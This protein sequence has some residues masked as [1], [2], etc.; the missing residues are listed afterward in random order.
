MEAEIR[1]R[2]DA[3]IHARHH[4]PAWQ[5]LAARRAPL[6]LSCLQTLFEQSQDGVGLDDALR[7]LA[8]MLADHANAGEFEIG[9]E[10]F[11]AQARK[12]LRSWIRLSLVV[13]REGR[14]YATDAFEEALRFVTALGG[15]IM[16]STA[17]R[18]SVVQREIEGLESSLNPDPQSRTVHL[19]H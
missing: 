18:L 5:L 2:T 14:V 12:E 11:A 1:E 10:D 3:Y 19:R 9:E 17:S 6:I 16:T 15:R 7:A 13:E 8:E 4:H